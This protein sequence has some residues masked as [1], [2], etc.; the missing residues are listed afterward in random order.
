M[1]RL[2]QAFFRYW[3]RWALG[4]LL[5][6]VA[7]LYVRGDWTSH[8]IERQD[9]IIADM[10]MRLEPFELDPG[11]VIVDIDSRSLTEVGRFPWSRNVL[12]KLVTQLTQHYEVAGVGFDVSFPEPDT[13]SGYEVLE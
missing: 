5:T 10:R 2:R 7:V 11:I 3:A 1:K 6:L 8:T 9:T 12:A 13:S 4:L